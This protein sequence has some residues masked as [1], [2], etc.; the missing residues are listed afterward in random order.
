MRAKHHN[1]IGENEEPSEAPDPRLI[2]HCKKFDAFERDLT[3]GHHIG[4]LPVYVVEI[5]SWTFRR[6][7]CGFSLAPTPSGAVWWLRTT[8]DAMEIKSFKSLLRA[9]NSN[10][11]AHPRPEPLMNAVISPPA[12][13]EIA[14]ETSELPTAVRAIITAP[15]QPP[16]EMQSEPKAKTNPVKM[17]MPPVPPTK[18][19]RTYVPNGTTRTTRSRPNPSG[20]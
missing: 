18:R 14:A 5:E 1:S 17:L 4:H 15:P 8:K 19:R 11:W 6:C 16:S 9:L 13:V 12:A 3:D 10:C 20:R 7:R 2:A